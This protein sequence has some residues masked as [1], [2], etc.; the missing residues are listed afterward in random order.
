M[1]PRPIKPETSLANRERRA[2]VRVPIRAAVTVAG[3]GR[4]VCG[5][6]RNLS[7]GGLFVETHEIFPRETEVWVELLLREGYSVRR[8]RTLAWVAWSAPDGMGLQFDD[9]HP[10][11]I[12]L[13]MRTV[14]RF[15]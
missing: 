4:R 1:R 10:D 11:D 5:W 14:E 15:D 8:L 9:L 13:L 3:E 12:Q 7:V 6:V 2:H